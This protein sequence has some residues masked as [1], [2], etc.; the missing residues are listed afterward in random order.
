MLLSA[1]CRAFNTP[2]VHLNNLVGTAARY[3]N[4]RGIPTANPEIGGVYLGPQAE[5]VFVQQLVSDL[6]SVMATLNMVQAAPTVYQ[7]QLLF[8]IKSR[9]EVN[10]SVGGFLRSS[11]CEP[12]D[13]GRRI[14]KDTKLGEIIDIHSFQ[15][16]EELRSPAT[17]FLFFSRYSGVV[18]VGA[19][20]FALAEE[21]SSKW[22]STTDEHL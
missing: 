1:L 4:S 20:A 13:L 14:E 2:F 15:I 10:P 3:C 7:K 11:F 17:G 6:K 16:V 12:A 5:D 22:L 18:D 19:K 9:L 21:A 8:G